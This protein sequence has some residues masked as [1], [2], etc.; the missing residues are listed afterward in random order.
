MPFKL[1]KKE[2]AAKT[3]LETTLTAYTD[4]V[5]AASSTY[6]EQVVAADPANPPD[7]GPLDDAMA[8][9]NAYLADV[10]NFINNVAA[11]L[12]DEFDSKSDKGRDS[13][14]AAD[15]ENMINEWEGF[16]SLGEITS[17]LNEDDHDEMRTALQDFQDLPD[18]ATA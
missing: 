14:V 18:D 9:Y 11:R 17:P 1:D 13:D 3:L 12:R 8:V 4:D 10:N 2:A 15:A 7:E 16:S 5:I 6:L